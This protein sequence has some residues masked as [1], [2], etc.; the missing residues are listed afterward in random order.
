MLTVISPAKT[1]D[2]ETPVRTSRSSEPALLEQ[3][4]R[5]A[6]VMRKKRPAQLQKLMGISQNLATLN[7][8]RF[9]A[10]TT[11]H[12]DSN[13]R[14][15]VL[16]FKG[17]VYAGLEAQTLKA[18]DLDFAQKHLRIL[19][20]LYGVLRPLD[21]I[22]PYRLEMGTVLRSRG[23]PDLYRFWGR[24][25]T[26][27]LNEQ[28][29]AIGTR[30]LV[31]LASNEYFK[32][33]DSAALEPTVVTPVFKEKRGDQY[34]VLSFFAKKARGMM[35]RY[36]IDNRIKQPEAMRDFDADG[37]AFNAAL[38]SPTQYVFTR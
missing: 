8:E 35:A 15:A 16:A 23:V 14:Q 36:L 26:Q 20:G 30:W 27:L 9:Q 2:Y 19:S 11:E 4:S 17:D 7:H 28:A 6:D 32:V 3:S 33:I 12:N 37:Y 5:L 25:P 21:R 34:R 31:N 38:S 13:S 1:L 24:Q 22:Q 29:A 18:R 10:W